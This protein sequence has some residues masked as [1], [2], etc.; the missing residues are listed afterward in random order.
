[1]SADEPDGID[2]AADVVAAGP[3]SGQKKAPIPCKGLP[4]SRARV[5][6]E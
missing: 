2:L 5:A 1:M 4:G 3:A 6:T